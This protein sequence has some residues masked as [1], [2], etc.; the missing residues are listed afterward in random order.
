MTATVFPPDSAKSLS[1]MRKKHGVPTVCIDTLIPNYAD[2]NRKTIH[3]WL[4]G[5]ELD[6]Q[7][8]SDEFAY[9]PH[10]R[11]DQEPAL[12]VSVDLCN[13]LFYSA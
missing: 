4:G 6:C 11:S 10:C 13:R 12:Y 9:N 2:S 5:T 8:R 1:R 3:E 7:S